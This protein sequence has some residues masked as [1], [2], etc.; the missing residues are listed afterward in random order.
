MSAW[1]LRSALIRAA[2][3]AFLWWA[4]T[5]GDP[6]AWGF[7][8]VAV[9][10]ATL[11]SL[12]LLPPAGLRWSFAGLVRFVAFFSVQTVMGSLDVS[13]RVFDPRLPIDPAFLEYQFRLSGEP[14]RV[15]FASVLSLLPGTISVDL[16]PDGMTVHV[17]DS[18][19]P[20]LTTLQEM[21][22]RIAAM[23]DQD[24]LHR[25]SI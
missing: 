25:G 21:E 4:I 8:V 10:A 5:E 18:R 23:F 19:L 17:I 11:A 20:V 6:E 7:G 22:E 2:I 16:R 13:R 3:I 15:L 24:L 14:P 12:A 1:S 9:G